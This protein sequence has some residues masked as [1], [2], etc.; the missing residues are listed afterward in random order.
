MTD[1]TENQLIA[2][3]ARD[4]ISQYSSLYSNLPIYL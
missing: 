2:E 3:L 4:L 1:K